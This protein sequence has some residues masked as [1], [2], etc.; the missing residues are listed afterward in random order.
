MDSK[1]PKVY[2]NWKN[3]NL[4][5]IIGFEGKTKDATKTMRK[6]GFS[7]GWDSKNALQYIKIA[8][9]QNF[10]K[11]FKK[12]ADSFNKGSG[13]TYQQ[14]IQMVDFIMELA[15]KTFPT[16]LKDPVFVFGNSVTVVYNVKEKE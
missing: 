15:L 10:D 6:D 4:E 5:F 9:A 13:P 7:V 11:Q 14:I 12:V 8:N 3:D 2:L 16:L 1:H